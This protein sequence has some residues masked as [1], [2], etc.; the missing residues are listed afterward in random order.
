MRV[1]VVGA[2]M[3]G[4]GAAR[5][6]H[7]AG[8]AT[9]V[10]EKSRGLGGRVATRRIGPYVFD[11]GA[12]IISPRGTELEQVILD[13]L[14]REEL[15][16]IDRP[17]HM[18]SGDRVTPVDPEGG[19]LR[20]FSYRQGNNTLAKLLADGLDVRL[21]TQVQSLEKS[22]HHYRIGGEAFS[23]VVLT[24]PLPQAEALLAS[25]NDRRTFAGSQYR[26]CLSVMFCVDEELDRPYHALIDPDQSQPLTW[27]SLEHVKVPG[28]FRAPKGKSAVLA[29]MSARYSRYSFE[30]P[31]E[32]ILAETWVDVR[33]V[34][35]ISRPDFI[36]AQVKRWRYSHAANTVGF[37]SANPEGAKILVAGDGLS[38][39]RIHQAYS[40]GV[41]AAKQIMETV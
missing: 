9:V 35:H 19:K 28:G 21:E 27:L 40:A 12:T 25:A 1:A 41:R 33:R 17:I 23:H 7:A 29:Q 24:P 13:S 31:D 38:G 22:D 4:L 8:I 14:P 36:E 10:F 15:V 20:R 16:E 18:A 37:E 34:L 32:D 2:G 39:A 30:R 26:Q 11:H 6:L 5:T 3:A